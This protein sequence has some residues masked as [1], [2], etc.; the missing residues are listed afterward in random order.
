MEEHQHRPQERKFDMGDAL[1]NNEV[2]ET[3]GKM[4]IKEVCNEHWN[5]YRVNVDM[6]T[7]WLD[8]F[9]LTI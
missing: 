9:L 7:D 1:N 3:G 6:L 5:K 2:A 8:N 4:V